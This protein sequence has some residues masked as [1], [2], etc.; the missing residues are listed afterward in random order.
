MSLKENA[1][2]V[3]LSISQWTARKHDKKASKEITRKHD[4]NSNM[5]RVNKVLIDIDEIKKLTKTA[6]EIRS[7]H[8]TNTL[9]WLQDGVGILPIANH[10]TYIDWMR[11]KKSQ[12][13][14]QVEAFI[15]RYDQ[16]V[17]EAQ[18]KLGTLFKVSDYPSAAAIASKFS[19]DVTMF[20]VPESGD[21]RVD[22]DEE[23]IEEMKKDLESKL[24]DA[25]KDAMNDLWDR[26]YKVVNHMADKLGDRTSHFKNSIVSNIDELTKLLPKLNISNDKNL[27]QLRQEV[28]DK[29]TPYNPDD[30]RVD[31]KLRKSAAKEAKDIVDKMKGFM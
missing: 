8:A 9:P 4:A 10:A 5:A 26:L 29:L 27:E 17:S 21:F 23:D 25:Q 13:K 16:L 30:L 18:V 3:K 22:L 28:I 12:W 31:S 2:L 7:F 14:E 6:N 19:I 11:D 24:H 1:L 15:N 20:P